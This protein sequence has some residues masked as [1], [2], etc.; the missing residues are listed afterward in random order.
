MLSPWAA[1]PSFPQNIISSSIVQPTPPQNRK[2]RHRHSPAQL[3]ALNEL[4]DRSEHPPLDQRTTLAE[5]LG[6]ETKTVNAWFQNKRASSKKRIR[7]APSHETPSMNTAPSVH[8]SS[9]S[10]DPFRHLDLDDI[11][12]DGYSSVDI[13][14]SRSASVVPSEYFS[15]FNAGHPDQPQFFTESDSMPRR[16]RMRPSSEQTDELRKL[17]NINPHP[18]TEQRQALSANIGMRYQSITN[19]FQNQRSLSKKKKEDEAEAFSLPAPKAEY[20]HET[21]QYS[22]FP[23]PSHHPSLG[24]PPPSNHPSLLQQH[25]VLRRSPSISPSM[26]DRSPRRSSSRRSTTPYSNMS[27]S[28]SRPRRSR[29]EPYQLDAL[30]EL[31][32]K[33]TTPTIEERSALALEIG[34]DVG[35]VTN[36][37]RNLRQT[38]RKRAKKGGS[39]EDDDDDSFH[40]R[41]PYSAFASRSGTPSLGSSSSSMNDDSMDMDADDYDMHHAHS[42]IGSE[43]EYQEAVT[44]S[45]EPSPS[46]PPSSIINP[47]NGFSQL[48]TFNHLAYHAEVDKVSAKQFSGI[49][50]EDA[51]LLLSFHQHIVH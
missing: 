11:P 26:E 47:R 1:P 7:G 34:M 33:T 12:D 27:T 48:E 49:R 36:W 4:F 44:P 40:G 50:I 43:D 3:A 8:L 24:L 42:D 25:S 29:P 15:P 5:R 16:M 46:P 10:N 19:W 51:L 45:P 30:K 6:M 23:P 9:A 13:Q 28:F 37:F 22:A 35:K 2:P 21:R 18:T 32:E 39:G 17:Y 38:A 31:F 41:D 14:H 20:P